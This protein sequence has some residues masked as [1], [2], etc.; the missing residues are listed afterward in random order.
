MSMLVNPYRYA[1]SGDAA[2]LALGLTAWYDPSDLSTMFQDT[3]GTTP[4]AVDAGVARINDKSGNGN[5]LLK[6]TGNPPILRSSGGLYYL[7]FDNTGRW[8]DC[9]GMTLTQPND[10]V[11]GTLCNSI[12]ARDI[13]D[14]VTTRQAVVT[15]TTVGLFAGSGTRAA[16]SISNS[17]PY[18]FTCRF[19]GAASLV[20]TNGASTTVSLTPGTNGLSGLRVGTFSGT[21]GAYV[22]YLY[23][24]L[25]RDTVFSAGELTTVEAYMAGKSG[26]TL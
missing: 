1:A 6:A 26:V 19:D 7:E 17:V 10:Y 14:G 23:G 9:T 12:T 21:T 18:V 20:R 3:A 4:A 24:L 11:L 16:G 13:I 5:T 25:I 22:G 8:L 2:I 15:S